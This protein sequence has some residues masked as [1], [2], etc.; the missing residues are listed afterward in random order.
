M[1]LIVVACTPSIQVAAN[2]SKG[3]CDMITDGDA[4]MA[5]L[6]SI[7]NGNPTKTALGLWAESSGSKTIIFTV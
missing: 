1:V 4:K 6:T 3:C 7:L 5:L 2:Q